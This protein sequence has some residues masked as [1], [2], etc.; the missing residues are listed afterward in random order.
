ME[1]S[2]TEA[3]T[4]ELRARLLRAFDPLDFELID[5]SAAHRGHAGAAAGGGHYR[6]RI[7]SARFEGLAK[8]ARHRLVYHAVGDLMGRDVHALTLVLLAP[9][10]AAPARDSPA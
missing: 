8:V 7:R 4:T 6:A 1:D 5:D 2:R 10:E 9:D 3:R